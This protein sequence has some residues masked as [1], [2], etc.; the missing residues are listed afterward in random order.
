MCWACDHTRITPIHIILV[1]PGRSRRSGAATHRYGIGWSGTATVP[2]RYDLFPS[3]AEQSGSRVG[4]PG[5]DWDLVFKGFFV[6]LMI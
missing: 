5:R 3:G 6:I 1:N 2:G 4:F